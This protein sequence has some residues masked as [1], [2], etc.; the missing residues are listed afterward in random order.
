[1]PSSLLN[2]E[3]LRETLADGSR[4][5]ERS[6]Q[7]MNSLAAFASQRA[8]DQDAQDLILRALEHRDGLGAS[9]AILDGLVREIG[10]FP[11]L[12]EAGLG[13]ADRI[14][15]E[16][17]RPPGME[18]RDVV[19]HRPQARV[20]REL[21][22][23]RSVILS[24]PTSFGKSLVID[25]VI[26]SERYSNILVV[27][28]TLALVDETRR[29]FARF[30]NAYRIITH[31]SQMRG[32]RNVFV[33]TQER[34]LQLEDLSSIDFLVIDEFYKLAPDRDEAGGRASLLN[35]LFYAVSRRGVPFYLLGPSVTGLA[36]NVSS[37][38]DAQFL[39]EPY[40]TVA[41]DLHKVH[42]KGDQLEALVELCE[43]LVGPTIVFCKSPTR[44]AKVVRR[45]LLERSWAPTERLAPAVEWLGQT[46]H[47]RW[48]FVEALARGI[49]V[50]HGRI[51]RALAQYIIRLFDQGNLP[52]LVCTS[53]LIE[54]VNTKA[55]NIVVMDNTINQQ[56]YDYFT[57]NNIRGRS[58]RMFQHFVGHVYLFHDPPAAT[59][60]LVDI[61]GISQ[62]AAAPDS[63]LV[64]L[65]DDELSDS[66]RE[67]IRGLHDQRLLSFGT[68]K[69]NVGIDPQVQ[70]RIAAEIEQD[71]QAFQSGLYWSGYPT[72]AQ[73]L[74]VCD[75]I[76]RHFGGSKLGSGSAKSVRQLAF[77]I[78]RLRSAPSTSEVVSSQLSYRDDPDEA[79]QGTLDFQRLW[80][81]FHFPR[82][83]RAIDRIQRDVFRRLRLPVGNF[84]VFASQVE[85]LFLDPATV[86][87]DEYGVPI[88]IARKLK[89]ELGADGDLDVALA[90]LG[91]LDLQALD[92][93]DFERELLAHAIE[94]LAAT[95]RS[96][97]RA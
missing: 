13:F 11:F 1:M 95:D 91:S 39:V 33:L 20:Y 71:P 77:L 89:A 3:E 49:G 27:V 19:F 88:E 36:E 26:A 42:W 51:P 64:Q 30:S 21:M 43:S 7:V 92:L 52:I 15:Y 78:D 69:E 14:A 82:L 46:Y 97:R 59:L 56:K 73:V 81:M 48:H 32:D 8:F 16:F 5:A 45:L 94:G 54:G 61:P 79:V 76:W 63:L 53:T 17:H 29:R 58:G 93:H 38:L 44:A 40:H 12:D 24:A 65:A 23:G 72:S 6:F 57:F 84:E 28:P 37:R 47:P 68:I 75:L 22:R 96:E 35:Q 85:C 18:E 4:I 2:S 62:S 74:F 67:R 25:A 66:S 10:L 9:A 41:S 34:G 87:L 55:R 90:R 31:P 60:P 83:L 86:A 80:A 50:H 70:L